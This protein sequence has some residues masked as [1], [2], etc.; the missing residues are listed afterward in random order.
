MKWKVVKDAG[1]RIRTY[2]GF[3]AMS[4]PEEG[5]TLLWEGDADDAGDA[6]RKAAAHR[7]DIEVVGLLKGTG[8]A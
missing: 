6:L 4:R 5:E 8:P 7:G 1:D 3:D 2:G